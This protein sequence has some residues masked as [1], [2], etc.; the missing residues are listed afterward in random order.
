MQKCFNKGELLNFL[1]HIW[2]QKTN[3]CVTKAAERLVSP[4]HEALHVLPEDRCGLFLVHHRGIP[5]A[6]A[7]KPSFN[8]TGWR[9]DGCGGVGGGER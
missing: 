9:D 3:I 7:F 8:K 2:I 5:S 1:L 6:G 4:L